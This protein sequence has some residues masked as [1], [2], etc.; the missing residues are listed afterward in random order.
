MSRETQRK[1]LELARWYDWNS[2]TPEG[3]TQRLRFLE[4]LCRELFYLNM[5]LAKDISAI[6]GRDRVEFQRA[7][8]ESMRRSKA[9]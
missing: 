7:I 3:V 8:D 2:H 6:E 4:D 5:Q 9:A 1:A